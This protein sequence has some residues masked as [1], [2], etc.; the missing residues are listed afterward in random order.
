MITS[1]EYK[2]SYYICIKHGTSSK[3][4]LNCNGCRKDKIKRL[5]LLK[6]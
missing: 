6:F 2:Y 3:T 4:K 5:F 1:K